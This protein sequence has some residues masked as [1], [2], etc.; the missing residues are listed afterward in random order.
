MRTLLQLLNLLQQSG[1]THF[2]AGEAAARRVSG[3]QEGPWFFR[4]RYN[5]R[6]LYCNRQKRR[7]L[8]SQ[9]MEDLSKFK[10]KKVRQ[11]NSGG[12]SGHAASN[13]FGTNKLGR[14]S[15][16][17]TIE[18]KKKSGRK[19]KSLTQMTILT[20]DAGHRI[21]KSYLFDFRRFITRSVLF[22]C[23]GTTKMEYEL[24]R[25]SFKKQDLKHYG[26]HLVENFVS[27][28]D[29]MKLLAFISSIQN[30]SLREKCSDGGQQKTYG[31][32][33]SQPGYKIKS[34]TPIPDVLSRFGEKVMRG[35]LEIKD[36]DRYACR[37][38]DRKAMQPP[39][40]DQIFLQKYTK[41]QSLGFHHDNRKEFG[42]L[43]VGV[44]LASDSTLLLGATNGGAQVSHKVQ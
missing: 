37:T 13:I 10:F 33:F 21:A 36:L 43:I 20:S 19:R 9:M 27:P 25:K 34:R 24:S 35:A 22:S 18:K 4:S 7:H 2:R 40:I 44:S 14:R 31:V 30:W 15:T 8:H 5:N 3:L 17:A 41:K 32:I 6:H 1:A 28:E 38:Y 26:F 23:D 42:E 16:T 29:E 39:S 11:T 12:L